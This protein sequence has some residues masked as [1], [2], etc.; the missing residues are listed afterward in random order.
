[1]N[2][3]PNQYTSC[4]EACQ[5]C[6]TACHQCFA[7]CLKEDD[8]KMLARCI[9]LNADCAAICGLAADAMAR[10]SEHAAA[11][12]ALCAQICKACG[13]ECAKYEADHCKADHCKACAQ[14]CLKCAQECDAMARAA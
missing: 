1:M 5:V 6:A 12:C 2:H 4:I 14:A 9:A 13:D 10:N 7:A 11:I 3:T 8:V